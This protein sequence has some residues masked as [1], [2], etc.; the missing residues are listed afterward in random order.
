MQKAEKA[1]KKYFLKP[2]VSDTREIH[3][4]L[5]GITIEEREFIHSSIAH[6]HEYLVFVVVINK[7]ENWKLS[8]P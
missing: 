1:T 2:N 4:F 6:I 5:G 3:G 8:N 7:H